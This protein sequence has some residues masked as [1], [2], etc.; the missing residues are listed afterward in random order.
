MQSSPR[1]SWVF[2]LQ[3]ARVV[4]VFCP[5]SAS[6]LGFP[7]AGRFHLHSRRTRDFH[8]VLKTD[9]KVLRDVLEVNCSSYVLKDVLPEESAWLGRFSSVSFCES[10]N[11]DLGSSPV[12][13][14]CHLSPQTPRSAQCMTVVWTRNDF[15]VLPSQYARRLHGTNRPQECLCT[16]HKGET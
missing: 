3:L 9:L 1:A 14:A 8:S 16:N 6:A 10:S 4:F 12:K 13:G 2:I 5:Y 15:R 11:L 7:P